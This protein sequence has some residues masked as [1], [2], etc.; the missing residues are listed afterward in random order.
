MK[1]V[2][3]YYYCKVI[4]K[5]NKEDFRM[6]HKQPSPFLEY[7]S[8]KYHDRFMSKVLYQIKPKSNLKSLS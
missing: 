5:L 4:I 2:L 3:T 6:P 7:L 1:K 8:N